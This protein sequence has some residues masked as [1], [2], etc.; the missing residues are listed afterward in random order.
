MVLKH[1]AEWNCLHGNDILDLLQPECQIRVD[2]WTPWVVLSTYVWALQSFSFIETSLANVTM[3]FLPRMPFV[4]W[5]ILSAIGTLL[6]F[7]SRASV[8]PS[9]DNYGWWQV[10]P[11]A[12]NKI[13]TSGSCSATPSR[14]I[15]IAGYTP[16]AHFIY[17]NINLRSFDNNCVLLSNIIAMQTLIVFHSCSFIF[18][19][20]SPRAMRCLVLVGKLRLH[21]WM[22]AAAAL[23]LVIFDTS[24]AG[25]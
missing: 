11:E 3:S 1:V 19:V 7:R 2:N 16:P 23:W 5:K 24:P 18:V 21:L 6:T 25:L 10:L 20:I 14:R 12:G 15:H 8:D 22:W 9:A 17:F 4:T 13:W